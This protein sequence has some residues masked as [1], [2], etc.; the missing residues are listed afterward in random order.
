MKRVVLHGAVQV[1]GI[2]EAIS[3]LVT[4]TS[5]VL[6]VET[7]VEFGDYLYTFQCSSGVLGRWFRTDPDGDEVALNFEKFSV[8]P[9]RLRI[10]MRAL[11]INFV[12]SKE[13]L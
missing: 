9:E 8:L 10:V 2:P 11:A 7:S 4:D 6:V 12:H 13:I 3:I 5:G 1:D